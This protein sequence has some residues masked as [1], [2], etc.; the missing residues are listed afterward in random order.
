MSSKVWHQYSDHIFC[1]YHADHS[2]GPFLPLLLKHAR[3]L[4]TKKKCLA[5]SICCFCN[6]VSFA[7]CGISFWKRS[8]HKRK[9][10]ETAVMPPGYNWQ[11]FSSL[12]LWV[13]TR[14]FVQET[15]LS[16]PGWDESKSHEMKL[17]S[18]NRQKHIICYSSWSISLQWCDPQS[19]S[20]T[21][22]LCLLIALHCSI[23]GV[24]SCRDNW[25]H[26]LNCSTSKTLQHPLYKQ[27]SKATLWQGPV[28]VVKS[29]AAEVL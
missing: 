23:Y 18:G 27:T 24:Q 16:I 3:T 28:P 5:P 26:E 17:Y 20:M 6:S 19:Y 4:W 29:S 21:M 22:S 2:N 7:S 13:S 12:R 10:V 11:I 14:L 9:I 25:S 8:K 1:F 15:Y